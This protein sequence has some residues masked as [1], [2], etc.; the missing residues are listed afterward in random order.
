MT[1]TEP[2]PP[3]IPLDTLFALLATRQRRRVL[4]VLRREQTVAVDELAERILRRHDRSAGP[5]ARE[6]RH[7][8]ETI[9]HHQDI[10]KLRDAD[11][12]DYDPDRERVSAT[13][14]LHSMEPYLELAERHESHTS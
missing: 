10:P 14:R 4:Y 12:V 3:A 5:S 11:V 8:I 6:R 9:L 7:E 13:D 1:T 2:T